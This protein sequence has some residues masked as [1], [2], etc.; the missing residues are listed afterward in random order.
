M[1]LGEFDGSDYKT[2]SY[3]GALL[4]VFATAILT[5]ILLNLVIAIMTDTFEKVMTS[6]DATDNRALCQ[7][8]SQ[9][10]NILFL[11]R[12]RGSPQYVYWVSYTAIS[13]SQWTS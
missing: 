3:T 12:K 2:E 11:N 9:Y 7:M 5:L 10:E 1:T 13:S 8:I 6:I 4:F